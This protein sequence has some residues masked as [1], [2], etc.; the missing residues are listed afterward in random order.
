M[1]KSFSQSGQTLIETLVAIFIL[2]MGV[3][4]AVGLANFALGSSTSV[5][6]QIIATGLAREGIEAV[7]NMRDTNWLHDTLST[8][9][10]NFTTG[11]SDASCYKHWDSDRNGGVYCFDPTNN[12][13]NCSG[14]GLSSDTFYLGLDGTDI[15]TGYWLLNPTSNKF[16]LIFT[17]A[18]SSASTIGFYNQGGSGVLCSDGVAGISDY[19]RKITITKITTVPY[20]KSDQ[21]DIGPKF[22]VQSQVWWKDKNCPRSSNFPVDKKCSIELD[23]YLTNWKNY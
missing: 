16:G 19:C 6:K 11:A 22:F 3:T 15:N 1:P 5:T 17:P 18:T 21:S 4:A 2:T 23:T 13:G 10:Y 9:C 14:N 8:N 7:K 12:G 20:D